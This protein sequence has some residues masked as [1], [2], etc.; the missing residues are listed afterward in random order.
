MAGGRRLEP[1]KLPPRLLAEL[2]ASAPELPPEV[3]LGP[4]VGE[5]ACAIELEAG[6]LVATTDPI[7]LAGS[8]VARHAVTVNANDVAAMGVRPRWFLAAV[9]LP[10]G[11]REAAVRALFDELRAALAEVGAALVGGHTEVTGVVS[12]PLVVGQ[13]LGQAEQGRLLSSAGLAPGDV[14]LQVGRAPVEA[15]AVLAEQCA[16]RLA[17]LDAELVRRARSAVESPGISV[18]AAGLAAVALGACAAH[19]PT[20]GGLATGLA[21]LATASGVGLEV[22]ADAV[23]WFEPGV[24]VC[25]AL[26]VDPW[27]A[28]AS[29]CLLTGFADDLVAGALDGF[30]ARGLEARAIARAVRG[31][32]TGLREFA[33]DEVARLLG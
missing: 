22:D 25:R 31:A 19:D 27:G 29:G 21:E 32:G 28:L 30:A 2:L 13:M 10:P 24:A 20:E 7:T 16:E 6:M 1:G 14:V 17:A 5:D 26:G 11:T 4:S 18:V 9:L 12:Q 8:G 3:R 23:L 15:A 33:R